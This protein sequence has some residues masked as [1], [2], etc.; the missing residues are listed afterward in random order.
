M[1]L[2]DAHSLW[3]DSEVMA[4]AERVR[5]K[6]LQAAQA[7]TAHLFAVQGA[8]S[9]ERSGAIDQRGH[10]IERLSELLVVFDD[11]LTDSLSLNEDL[12][13]LLSGGPR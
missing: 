11:I 7:M 2:E 1:R 13:A 9:A 12:P 4:L 3:G 6:S 8:M 10:V 5:A